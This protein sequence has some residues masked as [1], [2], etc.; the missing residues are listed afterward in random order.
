MHSKYFVIWGM[1]RSGTSLLAAA[2]RVFGAEPHSSVQ[3]ASSDNPKG[4]FEDPALV[5]LNETILGELGLKWHSLGA[6]GEAQ[7]YM[8]EKAGYTDKALEYL[9]TRARVSPLVMLKDPRMTRLG[10][11]WRRVF[12][13]A[14]QAPYSIISWRHPLAV[15]ASLRIRALKSKTHAPEADLRHGLLLWLIHTQAALEYTR[16]YP[17]SLVNYDAFLANPVAGLK[18][19]AADIN[20]PASDAQI[21]AFCEDFVERKYNHHAEDETEGD[22]PARVQNLYNTLRESTQ[23]P[24][25]TEAIWPAGDEEEMVAELLDKANWHIREN[26]AKMAS[27]HAEICLLTGECKRMAI[28][29][30]SQKGKNA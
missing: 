5:R 15:A 9:Q 30:A 12:E 10:A 7:A 24:E 16:G 22:L 3:H 13:K 2:M 8:L 4:Y 1:H 23:C 19:I 26:A 21:N 27:V 17:R 29:L 11:F 20:F 18:A 6:I 14:G 25:L 28:Q